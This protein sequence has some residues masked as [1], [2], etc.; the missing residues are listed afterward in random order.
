MLAHP[1][2]VFTRN[3]HIKSGEIKLIKI[4]IGVDQIPEGKFIHGEFKKFAWIRR[5]S[6]KS[7]QQPHPKL[8]CS[9]HHKRLVTR[10][11]DCD[12]HSVFQSLKLLKEPVEN[13]FMLRMTRHP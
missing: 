4:F 2:R 1:C 10:G 12:F 9:A 6:V 7:R 3:D 11:D 5:E 8:F 13:D